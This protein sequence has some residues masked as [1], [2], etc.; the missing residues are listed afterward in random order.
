MKH[1]LIVSEDHLI[2][3]FLLPAI[4]Y[5][6]LETQVTFDCFIINGINYQK[7]QSLSEDFGEVFTNPYPRGFL[8]RI[9]KIRFFG[10]VFGLWK[11]SGTLPQYDIVHINFHHYYLA[12]IVPR[13]REKATKLYVTFFGSDFNQAA[14]Y[15]H[16]GNRFTV[17]RSDGIFTTNPTLLKQIVLKYKLASLPLVKDTI[18]PLLESFIT[19]REFLET[20]TRELAKEAINA[21]KKIL[22]CGYNASPITNHEYIINAL[23]K[24]KDHLENYKVIFPMT[25]GTRA[26]E[27]RSSVM[28]AMSKSSLDFLILDQYLSL[29][30]LHLLRLAA[31]IFINVPSRD[32]MS[33]SMLE[34]LASGSV[35]ITG[36]WL[37]YETLI[38]N[39]IILYLVEHYTQLSDVLN[40]TIENLDAYQTASVKNRDLVMKM[41][42]WDQIKQKWI[43]YYDLYQEA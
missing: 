20:H 42:D 21:K 5:L 3:T 29:T 35:V 1:I 43:K 30:Q 40:N 24:S 23:V 6:K 27:T 32:Q 38:E 10:T 11:V 25:Y 14:W 2:R 22:V 19:Y 15:R 16:L 31:D 4:R 41:T 37:P 39:G 18:F 12:A 17:R 13:L 9:P 34:H 8:K 36:K 7:A 33:A 26:E 28:K